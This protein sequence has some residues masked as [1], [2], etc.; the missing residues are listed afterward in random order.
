MSSKQK[1]N[2]GEHGIWAWNGE[3]WD[4]M[5]SSFKGGKAPFD[6][7]STAGVSIRG[8]TIGQ[9]LIF[10]LQVVIGWT[11]KPYSA[12]ITLAGAT[13]LDDYC[14]CECQN[15]TWVPV[16]DYCPDECDPVCG[17]SGD[18]P[19]CED[20]QQEVGGCDCNPAPPGPPES[21]AG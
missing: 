15:N 14:I 10:P 3:Q 5:Q 4:E 18:D 21:A 6:P 12:R 11:P 16:E 1:P 8:S 17:F 2:L 13:P 9:L 20:G 7:N 19:T